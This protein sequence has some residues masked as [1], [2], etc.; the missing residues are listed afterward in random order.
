MPGLWCRGR[1]NQQCSRSSVQ[2]AYVK[3]DFT[4]RESRRSIQV[5]QAS[6]KAVDWS[7]ALSGVLGI[8]G[9][10]VALRPDLAASAPRKPGRACPFDDVEIQENGG[11]R[12]RIAM[13]SRDSGLP[14][15]RFG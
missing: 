1:E 9:G 11:T 12:R 15:K 13:V 3:P 6:R 4:W 10:R 14:A 2:R 8:A 7:R 5:R